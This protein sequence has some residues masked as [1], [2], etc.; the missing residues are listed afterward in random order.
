M[1]KRNPDDI[2]LDRKIAIRIKE[3]RKEIDA[4]QKRFAEDR[5]LDRQILNRWESTTNDRGVSIHTINKF[6]ELIG[7]ELKDFFDS[8]PFK[9]TQKET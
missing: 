2:A 5:G 7:M 8:K 9:K 4:N 3:L 1:A 6:C